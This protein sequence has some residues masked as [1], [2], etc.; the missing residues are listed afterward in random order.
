VSVLAG[1]LIEITI[2]APVRAVFTTRTGGVSQGAWRSLNLA[3]DGGDRPEAVRANREILAQALG[4]PAAAVTMLHQVHGARVR[5]VGAPTHPGLFTGDLRGWDRADGLATRRVNLPL[6]VLAADCLPILLWRRAGDAVAAV[7]A[8]WRGIIGGIVEAAAGALGRH[9]AVAA[10]IGPGIGPCCYEVSGDVRRHFA[11]RFGPA[12]VRGTAV[13]LA[14]SARV[15]L[16]SAGV[17]EGSIAS[18]EAC[19]SCEPERFF[20]HRG[21]GGA[22][23]RQAGLIWRTGDA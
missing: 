7:H 21:S 12:V 9:G 4:V 5:H 11:G 18:V 20:S 13:D 16:R 2:D 10:A 6:A 15:A 17:R 14:A 3:A 1:E 22:C 23:G 8:G 19:T